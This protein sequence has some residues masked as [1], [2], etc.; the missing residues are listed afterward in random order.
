MGTIY[1]WGNDATQEAYE[2]GKGA[3][4]CLRSLPPTPTF[5]EVLLS[6]RRVMAVDGWDPSVATDVAYQHEIA[7]G[8][9]TVGFPGRLLDD[10]TTEDEL[11]GYT[12]V[13]TRYHEV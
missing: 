10:T 12:V 11:E 13:G 2:L 6:V 8:I 1:Y 4:E 9:C 5:D 3:W 7:Q